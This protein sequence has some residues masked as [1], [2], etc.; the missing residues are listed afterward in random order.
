[1]IDCN[2]IR[3]SFQLDTQ[4]YIQVTKNIEWL[5]TSYKYHFEI[6]GSFIE[7]T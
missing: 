1:M 4:K 2:C 6:F 7:N 3:I 5:V